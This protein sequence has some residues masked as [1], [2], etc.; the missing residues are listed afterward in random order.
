MKRQSFRSY[1][2]VGVQFACIVAI[3]VSGP[4]FAGNSWFFTLELSG[5]LL[6]VWAIFTMRITRVNV[7]P[8]VR[9]G[10]RLVTNGPYRWVRHPM[11]TALLLIALALVCESFSYWRG[12]WWLALCADLVVKLSCE[13]RFLSEVFDDYEAYRLRTW[14]LVPWMF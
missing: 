11:Y 3:L 1:F 13:E 14:R 7:F 8:E 2:L 4:W 6:L 9:T 10:S 5:I 12:F